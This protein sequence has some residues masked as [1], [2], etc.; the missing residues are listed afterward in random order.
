MSCD[1]SR[2]LHRLGEVMA[3]HELTDVL[4]IGTFN[5]RKI[6]GSSRLSQHS[7]GNAIDIWG[8]EDAAGERYILEEHS[9]HDTTSPA[10]RAGCSTTWRRRCTASSSSISS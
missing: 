9:D 1:L 3:E 2:A 10:E 7:F 5:C 6:A 4:H 8:F